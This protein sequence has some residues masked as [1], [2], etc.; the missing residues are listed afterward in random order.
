MLRDRSF[1]VEAPKIFNSLPA[2]IRAFEGS[3]QAMKGLVDSLL[4]GGPDTPLSD[5][6]PTFA[7]DEFGARSNGL[8]HWLRTLGT[9]TY[10]AYI[11]NMFNPLATVPVGDQTG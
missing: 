6:R 4:A 5:T 2:N 11:H 9:P 10:A 7:V 3:P 8:R 1:S